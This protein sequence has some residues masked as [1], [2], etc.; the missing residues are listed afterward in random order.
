VV[1]CAGH[2]Q[3]A[4][5]ERFK[6]NKLVSKISANRSVLLLASLMAATAARADAI[7]TTTATTG[8]SAGQAAVVVVVGAMIS[9]RAVIWGMRQ[10]MRVIGGR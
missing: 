5:L 8:I 7:D 10:V 2:P 6:M 4:P 1:H 3:S 9:Y